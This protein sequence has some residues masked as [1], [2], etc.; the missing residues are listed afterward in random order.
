MRPSLGP[1]SVCELESP[2]RRVDDRSM[3]LGR[4]DLPIFSLS[5]VVP[6][7]LSQVTPTY[8]RCVVPKVLVTVTRCVV[9]VVKVQYGRSCPPFAIQGNANG[10]I[11][12]GQYCYRCAV[13]IFNP[14]PLVY[15]RQLM[16]SHGSVD[17][18][19]NLLQKQRTTS[20]IRALR[21]CKHTDM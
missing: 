9:V 3:S 5:S 14:V 17:V 10:Y 4:L 21:V 2:T 1:N 19:S 16:V 6:A 11:L 8:R 15:P 7:D 12:R 13:C 20:Q 18:R